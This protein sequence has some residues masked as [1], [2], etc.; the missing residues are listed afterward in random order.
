MYF[1]IISAS[2]TV[3]IKSP[4]KFPGHTHKKKKEG[5]KIKK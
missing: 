4:V 5:Q 2:C 3:N 1:N